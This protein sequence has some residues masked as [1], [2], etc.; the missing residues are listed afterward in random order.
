MHI[1]SFFLGHVPELIVK[2]I[3]DLSFFVSFT[4]QLS[5]ILFSFFFVW[6]ITICATNY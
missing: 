3:Y 2:N 1:F 6:S 5:V 4:L